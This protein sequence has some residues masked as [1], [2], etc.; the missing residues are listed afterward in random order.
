[1]SDQTMPVSEVLAVL[2][3]FAKDYE[4]DWKQPHN[5]ACLRRARAAITELVS[6]VERLK[7]NVKLLEK[8]STT[9]ASLQA[10]KNSL[11]VFGNQVKFIDELMAERD[12]LRR[13][14]EEL[15]Q[16]EKR[17]NWLSA[18]PRM[19][20]IRMHDKIELGHAYVVTGHSMWTLRQILDACMKEPTT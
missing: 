16:D 13:R 7:G 18:N 14:V 17:L 19:T 9:Q 15:E 20:E 12:A 1:M 10:I 5:A 6:E 4:V 3:D 2:D 11:E 8:M